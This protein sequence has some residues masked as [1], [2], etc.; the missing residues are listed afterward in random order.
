MWDFFPSLARN[1]VL[2]LF[3]IL[4]ICVDL[5]GRSSRITESS[6]KKHDRY[7]LSLKSEVFDE[8]AAIAE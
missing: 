7:V 4:A 5:L 8:S 1:W 2:G 3:D 6:E